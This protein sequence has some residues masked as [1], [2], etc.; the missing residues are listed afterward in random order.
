MEICLDVPFHEFQL[1]IISKGGYNRSS[2]KPLASWWCIIVMEHKQRGNNPYKKVANYYRVTSDHNIQ[3]W[4]LFKYMV[5]KNMVSRRHETRF[6]DK[7]A[8]NCSSS[9]R[10]YCFSQYPALTAYSNYH[11]QNIV[12]VERSFK[13][14]TA[15]LHSA[16][17]QFFSP[18]TV[19]RVLGKFGKFANVVGIWKKKFA[20]VSF[21][22]WFWLTVIFL[23]KENDLVRTKPI[24]NPR[25][26]L[27]IIVVKKLNWLNRLNRLQL[28]NRDFKISVFAPWAFT[29]KTELSLVSEN[30]SKQQLTL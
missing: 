1:S 22:K 10:W 11:T 2:I 9:P 21:N 18:G 27:P 17:W 25:Q 19:L 3:A 29:N 23:R 28:C 30:V 7:V 13:G 15:I 4:R 24:Q 16:Y 20:L 8:R 6:N 12:E 14:A 26:Q 5:R